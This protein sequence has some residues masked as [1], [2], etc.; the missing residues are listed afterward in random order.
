[1]HK[2]EETLE[3]LMNSIKNCENA[4]DEY[5]P[6]NIQTFVQLV[7]SRNKCGF[8]KKYLDYPKKPG[9]E[10]QSIEKVD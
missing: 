8:F 3:K 1:M 9:A 5:F 6:N 4:K 10:T 7:S 2:K